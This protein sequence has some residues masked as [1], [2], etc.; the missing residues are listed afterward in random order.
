MA[1][2]PLNHILTERANTFAFLFHLSRYCIGAGSPR[3]N[4]RN[5]KV[6]VSQANHDAPERVTQ[7]LTSQMESVLSAPKISSYPSI[8]CSK[9]GVCINTFF[10]L[11][12]LLGF[13]LLFCF[14]SASRGFPVWPALTCGSLGPHLH[15]PGHP[16]DL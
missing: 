14:F 8:H 7:V 12:A 10:S 2:S 5:H 6:A 15:P 11:M 16:L 9:S 3:G 1:F 4:Y 13:I